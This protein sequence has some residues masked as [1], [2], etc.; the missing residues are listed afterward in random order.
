MQS[1]APLLKEIDAFLRK[2]NM[3][4][5]RFGR[6]ATGE[7]DLVRTLRAGRSPTLRTVAKI[8]EFMGGY[9]G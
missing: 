6:E 1:D 5:S 7:A 9:R 4:D 8:R 2:W 3:T